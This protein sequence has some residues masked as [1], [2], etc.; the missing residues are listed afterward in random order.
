MQ[1]AE[2]VH[3]YGRAL[4]VR[5]LAVYGGA[6]MGQQLRALSRGVDVVVA[7]PG[8][9]LDFLN[10]GT[11]RLDR[12]RVLVL[13]EADE[14]L[15]MGFEEDLTALV[16]ATPKSRQTALFSATMAPRVARIADAYLT[17]PTRVE[18]R[19]PQLAAGEMPKVRQ[20][21]YVVPRMHKPATLAR[22]LDVENP[23]SAIVFCRTRGEVDELTESLAARGWRAEALHGGMGQEAR[24][25]VMR[26]FRANQI[27]LLV[28]TDVA[29]R[30]LDVEHVSHVVNY[31]VPSAPDQYVH[32][33]GRT[34]RAGR[35]GVAITIAEPRE[36]G[37]LRTIERV[38]KQPLAYATVP[39]P[40]DIRET[41]LARTAARVR[42]TLVAAHADLLAQTE[43]AVRGDEADDAGD[44]MGAGVRTSLDAFRVVVE[45]LA[46]EFDA[47]EVAAAAIRVAHEASVGDAPTD[48]THIPSLLPNEG[49]GAGAARGDRNDRGD[50]GGRPGDR[51][52]RF[53][54]R[55]ERGGRYPERSAERFAR[56]TAAD[57]PV[58]DDEGGDERTARRE[59]PAPRRGGGGDRARLWVSVGRASGVR[60][61]DLMGAI[62]NE[63]GL[64]AGDVG[65]IDVAE[66]FTLVEVPEDAADGVIA[67]LRGTTIRGERAMVRR[68]REEGE[69]G[70]EPRGR[71]GGGRGFDGGERGGGRGGDRGGYPRPGAPPRTFDRGDRGGFDRGAPRERGGFERGG[72]DRGGERGG[73]RRDE[74]AGGFPRER[75]PFESGE[76]GDRPERGGYPRADR[77]ERGGFDRG[78]DR[79]GREERGPR[80]FDRG[81][82]GG[83]GF[84]GGGGGFDRGGRGEGRGF[85]RGAPRRGP[86]RGR[87][88]R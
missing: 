1:V 36:R 58:G 28:A 55:V 65:A 23:T 38:T 76:R 86:G 42:E 77:P 66:R 87:D 57:L 5:V 73:F 40:E 70:G 27:E 68:D 79:G 10:R 44:G 8:R 71:F 54:A 26:R 80:P 31:D 35:E 48:E 15:D 82:R 25:R 64:D 18:I 11:L 34:G 16:E 41:R 83:G 63:A 84:G 13:D 67:A 7:T 20:T 14:M 47:M 37:S 45:Q 2:A 61:G 19:R 29:A 81:P 74:P 21:A 12:V 78:V 88:D 46:G 32:R 9:A 75:R 30:G 6:A 59:R 72:F 33:I 50:R 24:D 51:G 3:K 39:T 85:D 69:G 62:V 60:P 43:A 4:G 22:V 52:G 49:R 53:E 56:P 17:E